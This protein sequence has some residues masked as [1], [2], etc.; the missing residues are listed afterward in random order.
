MKPEELRKAGSESEGWRRKEAIS[1]EWE[2]ILMARRRSFSAVFRDRSHQ[3][4][5]YNVIC[6]RELKK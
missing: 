3:A 1:S 6:L 5:V 4:V 2:R